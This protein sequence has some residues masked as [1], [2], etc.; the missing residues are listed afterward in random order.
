MFQIFPQLI[1]LVFLALSRTAWC[2]TPAPSY[3]HFFLLHTYIFIIFIFLFFWPRVFLDDKLKFLILQWWIS[4]K[5]RYFFLRHN[6]IKPTSIS[7][8]KSCSWFYN[9][10]KYTWLPQHTTFKTIL[11]YKQTGPFKRK[12]PSNDYITYHITSRTSIPSQVD[13]PFEAYTEN[14][15]SP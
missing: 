3:I 9:L 15:A 11:P 7:S 5:K 2:A 13:V 14:T 6:N 8:T 1:A 12:F 4:K 10:F